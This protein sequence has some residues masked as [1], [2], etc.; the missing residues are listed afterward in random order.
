MAYIRTHK[1]CKTEKYTI[2]N[3]A[4]AKIPKVAALYIFRRS[5]KNTET[6]VAKNEA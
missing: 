1:N 4:E 5:K 6:D 2:H 3:A